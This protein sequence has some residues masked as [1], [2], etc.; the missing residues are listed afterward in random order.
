MNAYRG[1]IVAVL[2]TALLASCGQREPKEGAG[3]NVRAE[4]KPPV[5][6]VIPKG[7]THVFWKSVEAGALDAGKELGVEIRWKGPI[8]ENDRAQQI[9]VVQQF[10]SEGVDAIVLAPLDEE[11]L[12]GACQ[13]A[14]KKG[15]P[16]VIID[17]A[18]KGEAG[19]DF[20]SFVATDNMEGGRMAGRKL[21]ELLGGKG[22]VVLL[23]YQ[24]GSASTDNREGGFLETVQQ[25]N[26]IVMTSQNQYGG[27]TV[28]DAIAVAENIVDVLKQAQ[29]VFTP[30]E[31]TTVG[32]LTTLQRHKLEGKVAFVGFDASPTLLEGLKDGAIDALVV[33]NPRKMGRLG[34]AT[35]VAALKKQPVEARVDTGV[36]LVT[37]ENLATPEIQQLL[38]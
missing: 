27:P 21:A 38:Q 32:M 31:S 10:V 33:Q 30:N 24:V 20:V 17:S 35:A 28:G 16:V 26:Q 29:G 2:A 5:V 7:T 34:V 13:E 14:M 25:D 8:K 22:N 23:R 19:K 1:M 36:A 37:R 4:G 15:I 3:A 18:L 11:A 6:A 12:Q 9:Q